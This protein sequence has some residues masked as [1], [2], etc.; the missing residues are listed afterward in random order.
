MLFS[1]F[2][3][4]GI[5]IGYFLTNL[6]ARSIFLGIASGTFLYV[7]TSVVIVEEFAITKYRYGKFFCYVFG[8]IL[9][10]GIKTLGEYLEI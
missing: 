9:T 10:A 2:T 5:M 1:L 6:L 7:S 3:P 4:F 8:G